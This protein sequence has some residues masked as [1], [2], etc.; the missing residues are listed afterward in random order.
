LRACISDELADR[1]RIIAPIKAVGEASPEETI[2][3]MHANFHT[4]LDARYAVS[5][6]TIYAAFIHPLSPLTREQVLSAVRQVAAAHATF[7]TSYSS[8]GP[9]FG[10]R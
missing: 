8:G 10:G 5:G 4:A 7:G 3:A 2:A 1:M 6:G 9:A